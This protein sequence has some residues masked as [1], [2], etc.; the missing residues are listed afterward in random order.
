MFYQTEAKLQAWRALA[1]LAGH[2]ERLIYVGRSTSQVRAGYAA[3]FLE[4][5]GD[6]ERT[7]VREIQLQC[8]NGAADCGHWLAKGVLPVPGAKPVAAPAGDDA[9][10]A[11]T[12]PFCR[13][14][15]AK[16]RRLA[17]VG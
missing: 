13:P 2:G 8:W 11:A 1:V 14:K 10:E 3:A 5:L 4:I 12:L 7:Q 17:P 9:P 16:P 6:E 15:A